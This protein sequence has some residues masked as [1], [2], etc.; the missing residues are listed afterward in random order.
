M[1]Q[2][3]VQLTCPSLKVVDFGHCVPSIFH[4][5]EHEFNCDDQTD[6]IIPLFT[7]PLGQNRDKQQPCRISVRS[8]FSHPVALPSVN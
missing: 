5:L 2:D 8:A 4:R 1:V 7:D 3:S 6:N